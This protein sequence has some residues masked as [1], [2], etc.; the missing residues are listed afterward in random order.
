MTDN[1]T[2]I[3][4]ITLAQ[5]EIKI[6]SPAHFKTWFQNTSLLELRDKEGKIGVNN[7]YTADWLRK[8]HYTTITKTLSYIVGRELEIDFNIDEKLANKKNPTSDASGVTNSPL[9]SYS[10]AEENIHVLKR[11]SLNESYNFDNYIVGPSNKLAHAAAKSVSQKPGFSYNPLFIYGDTGLGKT[12][13]AQ[14]IAREILER[15]A[16]SKILYISSERFLI[17]MVNAIRSNRSTQ[18][19][20][21]Y[22]TLDLLIIDDIQFIYKWKE[23]QTEFFH[24]FNVL[25]NDKKQIILVSDRPPE[26]IQN[27]ESRLRSRFQGGMTVDIAKPDYETRL[28]ILEKKLEQVGGEL[29]DYILDFI[30]SNISDNIREL[31]GALQKIALFNNMKDGDLSLEEVKHILG[32]DDQ[33]KRKKIK[34]PQ[35]IKQVANELNVTAKD[36]KGPRRT[37][38]VAFARQICMYI[39]REDFSYKLE[40]VATLLN[41]KDHTTVIHAVDKIKSKIMLDEGFKDQVNLIREKINELY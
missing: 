3:W 41:R 22:R 36:I 13:L 26:E 35:V 14:A 10:P 2:D 8:H 27:L 9:L 34:A 18:F 16:T 7:S 19:R 32:R 40:D 15:D 1:L 37:A 12:H 39:L 33:N 17:D 30:A 4:K 20:E 23:T 6:D 11:A 25:Y 28:A 29:P 5:I 31:E 24:T 38:D 21:K